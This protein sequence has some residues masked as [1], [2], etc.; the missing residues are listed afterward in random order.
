MN[1]KE[2]TGGGRMNWEIGTDIHTPLCWVSQVAQ[3]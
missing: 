1:T 3:W 2:G